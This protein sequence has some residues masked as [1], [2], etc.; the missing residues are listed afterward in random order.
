MRSSSEPSKKRP[1]RMLSPANIPQLER[2]H[3]LYL[4]LSLFSFLLSLSLSHYL[5]LSF[6][7]SLSLYLSLSL[8][9]V[10]SA[11]HLRLDSIYV[12]TCICMT[13]Q[14]H[15]NI[16]CIILFARLSSGLCLLASTVPSYKPPFQAC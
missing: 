9:L 7:H 16:I 15:A 3:A 6:S 11:L 13:S 5:S 8:S 14:T 12:T 4:S 10:L 1:M 2:V